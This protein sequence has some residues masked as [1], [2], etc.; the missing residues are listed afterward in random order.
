MW[1]ER[2]YAHHLW[3]HTLY[4]KQVFDKVLYGLTLDTYHHTK[5]YLVTRALK[6]LGTG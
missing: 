5:T 6:S 4:K 2:A 1:Q 3:L